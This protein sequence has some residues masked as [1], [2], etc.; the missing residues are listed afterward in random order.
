MTF[1]QIVS[2]RCSDPSALREIEEEWLAATEGR[3]TLL[4][5]TVLVDRTDPAHFVTINEFESY[6]SAMVNSTLRETDEMARAVA[7]L[8]IGEPTY[9]DLDVLQATEFEQR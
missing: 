3:R 9:F 7:G 2:F 1:I 4:R 5:E 8:L 6:E